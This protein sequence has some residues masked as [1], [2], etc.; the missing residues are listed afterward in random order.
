MGKKKEIKWKNLKT[1][2]QCLRV[3]WKVPYVSIFKIHLAPHKY[4]MLLYLS[5]QRNLHLN[6]VSFV[7]ELFRKIISTFKK[8]KLQIPVDIGQ[9]IFQIWKSE[10]ILRT[11]YW[12]KAI[13][14]L[15]AVRFY[16]HFI[17][18]SGSNRRNHSRVSKNNLQFNLTPPWVFCMNFK[19]IFKRPT[20]Q[21]VGKKKPH[22]IIL[23]VIIR[24]SFFPLIVV[25][26]LD[27]PIIEHI[28]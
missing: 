22:K 4:V 24:S 26:L 12:F 17:G 11:R 7:L 8:W 15:A 14:Y 19:L 18:S 20:Q 10:I 3:L 27:N 25:L 16:Q 6:F 5:K 23:I 1:V 21:T 13:H 28:F 2:S 9:D